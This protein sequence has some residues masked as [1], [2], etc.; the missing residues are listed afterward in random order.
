MTGRLRAT[1]IGLGVGE[2]H[3]RAYL[4]DPRVEL[5]SVFDI[6]PP[7]RQR[8]ATDLGVPEAESFEAAIDTEPGA[9]TVASDS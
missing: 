7:Q 5:A 8:V 6:D 2:Q 1:V 3:A 4:A 9:S